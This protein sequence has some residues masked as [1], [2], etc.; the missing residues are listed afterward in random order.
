MTFEEHKGTLAGQ[1]LAWLGDGNNVALSF[2]HA[3]AQVDFELALACPP[4]FSIAEAEIAA[5]RDKGAKMTFAWRRSG[6][7]CG[8]V[9]YR[10][11]GVDER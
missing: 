3:A 6:G 5:A 4:D 11:L 2:V 10:L 8:G 9:D 1:K 7:R